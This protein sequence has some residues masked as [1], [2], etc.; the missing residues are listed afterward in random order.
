MRYIIEFFFANTVVKIGVLA[1]V[2]W[3]MGLLFANRLTKRATMNDID[4]VIK[5]AMAY[6]N[7]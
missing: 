7:S 3:Q 4:N 1:V 5:I 6:E 2:D